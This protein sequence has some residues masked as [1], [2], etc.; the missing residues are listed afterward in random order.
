MTSFLLEQISNLLPRFSYRFA[1]EAQLH[2]GIAAV[3]GTA[4]I[5]FE[6]ERVAGPKDRFDFFCS[7]IVIE[8]KVH[9]SFSTALRQIDRYIARDDVEGIVLLTTRQW[10]EWPRDNPRIY[11]DGQVLIIDKG[12]APTPPRELRGKPFRVVRARSQAF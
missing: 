4:G 2:K 5:D 6:H 9:G 12:P 3:L 11:G 8:A 7:G 10:G 1:D